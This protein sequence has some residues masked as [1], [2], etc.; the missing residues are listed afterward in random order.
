MAAI[1]TG[2][3]DRVPLGAAAVLSLTP[4]TPAGGSY[5]LASPSSVVVRDGAGVEVHAGSA[6]VA[7]DEQSLSATVPASALDALDSYTVEWTAT[8]SGAQSGFTSALEVCGG[9]FT[10]IAE[11]RALRGEFASTPGATLLRARA[12]A[13]TAFEKQCKVAFV[14]RAARE[15]LIGSG[16]DVLVLG[17]VALRELYEVKIDGVALSAGDLAA[18]T[19]EEPGLVTR[20]GGVIWPQQASIDVYY[21]HGYDRPEAPVVD[22]VRRLAREYVV[23]DANLPPRAVLQVTEYGNFRLGALDEE[24]PF[25]IPD[26]DAVYRAYRRVLPGVG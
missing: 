11:L 8:V 23:P 6:T 20:P 14:P 25:G 7:A 2:Q 22:A 1:A 21:A 3:L 15:S 5:T 10:T 18:L 17:H 9:Y 16:R 26:V 12:L 4:E 24:N 13:E 19:P